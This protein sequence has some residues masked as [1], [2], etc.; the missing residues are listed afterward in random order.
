[1]E[2]PQ[3]RST[4]VGAT[5]EV[6][7]HQ[8]ET[9]KQSLELPDRRSAERR[10]RIAPSGSIMNKR[11]RTQESQRKVTIDGEELALQN[12]LWPPGNATDLT[13]ATISSKKL[14][15]ITVNDL[16]VAWDKGCNLS[17]V[18]SDQKSPRVSTFAPG[19]VSCEEGN[20]N[21]N[22]QTGASADRSQRGR[23]S[24]EPKEKPN[25]RAGVSNKATAGDDKRGETLKRVVL[26]MD[27]KGALLSASQALE[28]EK[29]WEE[30][31]LAVISSCLENVSSKSSDLKSSAADLYGD[32]LTADEWDGSWSFEN[33]FFMAKL[34]SLE[35]RL[36]T[37]E[38]Y[39]RSVYAESPEQV[40][41]NVPVS[42]V[43]EQ[44]HADF[45]SSNACLKL[46]QSNVVNK[47]ANLP[48]VK[49]VPSRSENCSTQDTKQRRISLLLH[50]L[51]L[52]SDIRNA[53]VNQHR[54]LRKL[55]AVGEIYVCKIEVSCRT[56]LNT[57]KS[58]ANVVRPALESTR[59]MQRAVSRV[60]Q[61]DTS[62]GGSSTSAADDITTVSQWTHLALSDAEAALSLHTEALLVVK[63]A[64]KQVESLKS[65][66]SIGHDILL[67]SSDFEKYLL[68]LIQQPL[69]IDFHEL[70]EKESEVA[71]M[72]D[73]L[74]PILYDMKEFPDVITKLSESSGN[75]VPNV[76]RCLS[77]A[78]Q[79]SCRA[80]DASMDALINLA[81]STRA[82]GVEEWK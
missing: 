43:N 44:H 31:S 82:T 23:S 24:E 5:A 4:A 36:N 79:N 73:M 42:E 30:Y 17:A 15:Q 12:V 33:A 16:S 39:V 34:D 62:S 47:K 53:V 35:S 80:L 29:Q 11:T 22:S 59:M 21:T 27:V 8:A 28:E 74:L 54:I 38:G 49:I 20:K 58:I 52:V 19:H 41:A 69:D 60:G 45:A 81:L 65:N 48:C 2:N 55:C 67:H 6:T 14:T 68:D 9:S 71:F 40:D 77:A 78:T 10:K 32:S 37:V 51:K 57:V 18:I 66:E 61:P 13:A 63:E 75:E 25:E 7:V 3:A 70:R 1:M 76:L 50:V 46:I 72:R 64:R 56:M 26:S